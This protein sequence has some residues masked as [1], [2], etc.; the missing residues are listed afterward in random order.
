M[1]VR[2]Q[3]LRVRIPQEKWLSVSCGCCVLLGRGAGVKLIIHAGEFCPVFVCFKFDR[4][5]SIMR[6]P[7]STRGCCAIKKQIFN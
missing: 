1:A 4:E 5:V 7:W 3:G 6:R 2:L